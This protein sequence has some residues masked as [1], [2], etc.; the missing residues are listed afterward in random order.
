MS[1]QERK[2]NGLRIVG[3]ASSWRHGNTEIIV[4]E[5]LREIRCSYPEAQTEFVSLA[6]KKILPCRDCEGCVK[7]GSYCILPD[8]WLELVKC[9]IEPVPDGVII[10]SPVYHYS[11]NAQLRA[12]LERCTSLRK[13]LYA[14]DFPHEPPDWS[15]TVGGAVTVG[16]SIHGG[17]EHALSS[18]IDWFLINGFVVVGGYYAG[19]PTWLH[20]IDARDAVLEDEFGLQAVRKLASRVAATARLIK[21][22]ALATGDGT[23]EA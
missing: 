12:F 7:K 8:D 17:Q 19:G 1:H 3:I 10:G 16:Q 18:I 15:K 2:R 9:L 23:L 4:K 11:V 6:H 13:K 14:P 22:G 20:E 5:A 21:A